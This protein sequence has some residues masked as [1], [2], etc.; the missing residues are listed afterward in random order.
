MK[1]LTLRDCLKIEMITRTFL[2]PNTSNSTRFPAPPRQKT[3]RPLP[4]RRQREV[5]EIIEIASDG[6]VGGHLG[7]PLW[8]GLLTE[9]GVLLVD[10][11]SQQQLQ[12]WTGGVDQPFSFEGGSTFV[13]RNRRL[14]CRIEY[15]RDKLIE[16]L[17]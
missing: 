6:L 2:I 15:E 14:Q 7:E 8:C 16:E 11:V 17:T 4:L 12:D 13:T 5:E 10:A 3:H 1:I 9:P